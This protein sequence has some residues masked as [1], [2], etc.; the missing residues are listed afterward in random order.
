LVKIPKKESSGVSSPG[1]D[2]SFNP[3]PEPP[4]E[5][6]KATNSGLASPGS[7]RMFNPQPEPPGEPMKATNSGLASPGSKR[8]FNPQP[9]PP[10]EPMRKVSTGRILLIVAVIALGALATVLIIINSNQPLGGDPTHG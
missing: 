2:R 1:A 3:Q 7:K 10:G 6:M 5:P 9:E 8:M 4:G